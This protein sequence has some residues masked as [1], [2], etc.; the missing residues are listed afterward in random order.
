MNAAAADE[1]LSVLILAGGASTR[2]GQNK[3]WLM[4]DGQPLIERVIRRVLPVAQEIILSA[5]DE[6]PFAELLR[7]LPA[8]MRVAHDRY[9]GAGPLAGLHAGLSAARHDLTLLLASD[10]PF[11]SLPLI[12][13]LLRLA[14]GHDAVIPMAPA[15]HVAKRRFPQ[16]EP[17]ALI[18][19]PLHALYR[20]SCL[21]ALTRRLNCG[22]YQMLSFFGDVRTRYVPVE[23]LRAIDPELLSFF[24]VNTPGDWQEAQQLARSAERKDLH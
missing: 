7:R 24:N 22:E 6:A 1:P 13:Y 4:L 10:M 2:M 20:R 3:L 23:E 12:A 14:P 9:D 15:R 11:V 19:Q 18:E 21:P 16:P 5:N 17:G 8:P